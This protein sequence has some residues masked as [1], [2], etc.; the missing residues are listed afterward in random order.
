MSKLIF[1]VDFDWIKSK[2]AECGNIIR[3]MEGFVKTIPNVK[4]IKSDSDSLTV[5]M[6]EEDREKAMHAI[7]K[8]IGVLGN[9]P[10]IWQYIRM[11]GDCRDL[12]I[13][14]D[15]EPVKLDDA[16]RE[17]I[18]AAL[19]A[20]EKQT[21][22]LER[23][24]KE[25]AKK[26]EESSSREMSF[27]EMIE[28][29]DA[30]KA[31]GNDGDSKEDS[32]DKKTEPAREERP[33]TEAEEKK[34][35][36]EDS[37]I[38][39]DRG[40][41]VT[42]DVCASV[43]M[44]YSPELERHIRD[45]GK[46][47]PMLGKMHSK[48][49]VWSQNLLVAIDS[50]CGFSSFLQAIAKVYQGF[51]LAQGE[52]IEDCVKEYVINNTSSFENKYEDWKKVLER[53]QSMARSNENR[54]TKSVMSIDISQWQSELTSSIVLDYLRQLG[55]T[56]KNFTLVFRVPFMET[57]VVHKIS[58]VLN[59]VM[60][61]KT[62]NVAP[63]SIPNMVDFVK[64]ELV[65]MN[66]NVADDCDEYIERLIVREK[67][68]DSFFGFKTLDKIVKSIVYHK[69]LTNCKTDKVD[70]DINAELLKPLCENPD[71]KGKDPYQLLNELIGIEEVKR[72][73][74]E[75]VISIKT[76]KQQVKEGKNL[77]SPCIHMMFT[78]NPGTGK[79]T[80]ARILGRIMKEEGVL[81]KG[82]FYE[83]KGR[84]LCGRYVGETAP[85]T[86]TYCRDAY[87]SVLFIDEA[88]GLYQ[89][90]MGVDYGKEAIQTLIAEMENHRDDFCVIMAGYE[91]EMREMLTANQGLESRIP[92]IIHFPNYSREELETIFFKM[93]G[94]TFDYTEDL[95]EGVH[96]FFAD[97]SDE[98]LNDKSFSNARLVRNLFERA[99][100]KAAYR[101]SL[102]GE[103]GK[104]TIGKE[105]LICASEEAEFKKMLE[106]KK[107]RIG[108]V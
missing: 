105:D 60:M 49:C 77:E 41:K 18:D 40:G 53:A 50:G 52:K 63:V 38:I 28:E 23:R 43:P 90:D 44:K 99:W 48:E 6:P 96:Q 12:T 30:A 104:I 72:R 46:V 29:S 98:A 61:V 5:E 64:T 59:D 2:R 74:R 102:A 22:E 13:P 84:D 35:T 76:Q 11:G 24:A 82:Y 16:V 69:A 66:C 21:E 27:E 9:E 75:I 71:E 39:S 25:E 54:L 85:K 34:Q 14:T 56:A 67:S 65:K 79:T 89:H 15:E 107:K 17:A 55:D 4:L 7:A 92:Y 80:V 62:L 47:I 106:D 37:V 86:S 1:T 108:F 58:E 33:Q 36:E 91:D 103:E 32:S 42:A 95:K 73:I 19:E 57:Q 94:T 8:Q 3:K 26:K 78:G 10:K 20:A 81:R 70:R 51:D 31:S 97:I 68:D 88:Y 83:I 93:V 87:G 101:M 100:G 45:L